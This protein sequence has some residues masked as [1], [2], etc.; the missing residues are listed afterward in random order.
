MEKRCDMIE[1]KVLGAE[2]VLILFVFSCA[3]GCA[4]ID[5]SI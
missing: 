4:I 5:T 1:M 2:K 3:F